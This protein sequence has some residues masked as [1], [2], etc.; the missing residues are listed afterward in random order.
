ML[1]LREPGGV[2]GASASGRDEAAARIVLEVEGSAYTQF[3]PRS[4]RPG[5]T[6]ERAS[7]PTVSL[8]RLFDRFVE[9]KLLLAAARRQGV[10]LTP[11]E[12]KDYLEKLAGRDP[13]RRV[14]LDVGRRTIRICSTG[15]SSKNIP[16]GSSQDLDVRDDEVHAYYEEHRK[17]FLPPERVKVSQIL[18]D[19]ETRAVDVLRRARKRLRRGV[20]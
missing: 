2:A 20:P 4:L 7:S 5:T 6:P 12:K 15:L 14:R 18:L 8:S 11:E 19:T 13:A 9:E 1:R 3:R 16:A 10:T 17:D